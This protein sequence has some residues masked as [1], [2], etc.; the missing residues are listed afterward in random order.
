MHDVFISYSSVD[1]AVA[2]KVCAALERDGIRCWIAPRDVTPGKQ[3]G[4]EIVRAITSSHLFVLILS[5]TSN[6]SEEVGHEVEIAARHRVRVV[7]VLIANVP[8]SS[9]IEYFVSD[10]HWLDATQP[11]LEPHLQRLVGLARAELT[12]SGAAEGD[13][14]GLPAAPANRPGGELDVASLMRKHVKV[15]V[16]ALVSAA[17]VL[18]VTLFGRIAWSPN[19]AAGASPGL[20]VTKLLGAAIRAQPS[21]EAAI[22]KTVACATVLEQ[23]PDPNTGWYHV[24]Y[25]NIDGWV[26]QARVQPGTQPGPGMC[27]GAPA[28]PWEV[29]QTVSALD[30]VCPALEPGGTDEVGGCFAKGATAQLTNGPIEAS[31]EDW[32]K[33]RATSSDRGGP[34]EGWARAARLVR[35]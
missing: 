23:V 35:R 19:A 11:P 3:W 6:A 25:Q 8:L 15:L 7:P 26:G 32:F 29:G 10:R 20:V 30:Q 24:R 28:Q 31:G 33:V 17:I 13:T 2:D 21:S 14:P 5:A 27:A 16:T 1:R 18:G 9:N 22:L 4:A 12:A 34:V